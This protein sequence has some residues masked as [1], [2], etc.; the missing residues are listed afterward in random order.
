MTFTVSSI[1]SLTRAADD[2]A[3]Y[4]IDAHLLGS[5]MNDGILFRQQGGFRDTKVLRRDAMN[6]FR[7]GN[8]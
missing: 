8:A 4:L 6:A 7:G 2:G 5:E 1:L 3:S